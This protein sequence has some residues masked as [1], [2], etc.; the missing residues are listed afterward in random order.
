MSEKRRVLLTHYDLDGV[1]CD[2]LI[3]KLLIIEKRVMGGYAKIKEHLKA[4]SLKGYDSAIVTDVSLTRNQFMGLEKEY[5]THLLYVD[6]H[7]PSLS[8]IKE[9]KNYKAKCMLDT[10][11]SASGIIYQAF[12]AKLPSNRDFYKFLTAVDAYDCWRTH[13]GIFNVGYDLNTLFWKY[14]YK[15]F[16][17]RFFNSPDTNF[18]NH[19]QVW[20]SNHKKLRN[21]ALLESDKNEF[22]K[23]SLLVI[24]APKEFLNDYT[25]QYPEY[26]IFFILYIGMDNILTMSV[27]TTLSPDVIDVGATIGVFKERYPDKIATGGGHPCSGGCNFEAGV[28]FDD[29]ID[30]IEEMNTQLEIT[31]ESNE[32]K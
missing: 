3:S 2:I 18:K 10:R 25:L 5:G 29:I 20:I 6:H 1:V 11:F 4:G 8:M 23:N 15:S 30:I 32:A 7:A 26:D 31:R 16:F 21:K 13:L 28:T 12:E 22:G 9:C 24:D 17:G 19:E 27:R 14:G